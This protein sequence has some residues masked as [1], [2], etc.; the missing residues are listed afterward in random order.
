MLLIQGQR[1][2]QRL[3]LA[4]CLTLRTNTSKLKSVSLA[5][6]LLAALVNATECPSALMTGTLEGAFPLPVPAPLTLAKVVVPVLGWRTKMSRM[7]FVSLLNT[8]SLA[9][10]SNA[11]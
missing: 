1:R 11:T 5:A 7:R 9:K 4:L 6:K 10:L 8:R 2:Q 3:Y